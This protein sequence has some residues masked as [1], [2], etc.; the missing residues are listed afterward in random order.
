MKEMPQSKDVL[1]ELE[2]LLDF[3]A[4]PEDLTTEEFCQAAKLLHRHSIIT[5]PL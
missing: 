4:R 1:A 3:K 2:L 5:L